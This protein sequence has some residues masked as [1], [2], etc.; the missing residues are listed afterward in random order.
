MAGIS[1]PCDWPIDYCGTE[2]AKWL[3]LSAEKRDLY[4]QAA[5]EW[6]WRWTG[7]VLGLC[8]A[9]IRPCNPSS[10]PT[11]G[12]WLGDYLPRFGSPWMPVLL[13]GRWYNLTCGVCGDSCAC[14]GPETLQLPSH[15]HR[16]VSV[17][18]DGVALPA[19]SWRVDSRGRLVRVDGEPW[20]DYQDETRPVTEPG[21]WAVTVEI[22]RPVPAGGQIAAGVLAIELWKAACNDPS[23]GLPKRVQ[24]ISRQGVSVAMLDSFDDIDKGHTGI[25]AIDSWVSSVTQ[26]PPRSLVRSPDVPNRGVQWLPR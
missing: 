26:P 7:R 24:T 6:L 17:T 4:E 25:W 2:P 14:D 15:V 8:P 16:V 23:C 19:S 11:S 5:V 13:Q 22:G 10:V 18:V 12:R 3:E 1:G 9:E 21:T 20:P